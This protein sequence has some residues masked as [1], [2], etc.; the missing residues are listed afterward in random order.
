MSQAADLKRAEQA[1]WWAFQ[2]DGLSETLLG[3]F[4]AATAG[5]IH[6]DALMVP[7]ILLMAFLPHILKAGR[8][9]FTYPRIGYA[10]LN[11]P[12]PSKILG[13]V[14]LCTVLVIA[15][16]AATLFLVARED[17]SP[18]G[19]WRRWSPTLAGVI[20]CGGFVY[21]AAVSEARRYHAFAVIAVGLGISFS[22]WFP[23]SYTGIKLYL[24]TTGGALLLYGVGAFSLFLSRHKLVLKE[25]LHGN[26]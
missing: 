7:W 18:W 16:M 26:D 9:R 1:A 5:S 22:L 12:R 21:Q 15:G 19:L 4:L 3:I 10:K 24:L 23:E 13:G 25:T 17:G 11:G 20:L 2:E 14:A 6:D 8:R